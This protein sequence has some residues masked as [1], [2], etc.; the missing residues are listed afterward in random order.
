M[1]TKRPLAR[2]PRVT[3][4][5]GTPRGPRQWL[6][7]VYQIPSEPSRHRVFIWRRVKAL[8]AL[9]LRDGVCIA[10]DR[11]VVREALQTLL[12]ELRA[13]GSWGDLF[14]LSLDPPQRGAYVEAL[15]ARRDEEYGE[16]LEDAARLAARIERHLLQRDYAFQEVEELDEEL[17]KL[18]RWRDK[19]ARRDFFQCARAGEVEAALRR[20]AA[21]LERFERAVV[22]EGE[23]RQAGR[24]AAAAPR[25]AGRASLSR[26]Q[27]P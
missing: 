9:Y 12:N 8:G 23:D 5:K 13:F 3:R 10:P 7:L 16:V 19:V 26:L 4:A 18:R 1:T 11:P 22:K 24:V 17:Q 27:A 20:C 14:E 6:Q 15:N 21:E 2:R 25:R